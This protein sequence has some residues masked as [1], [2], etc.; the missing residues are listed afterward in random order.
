[1]KHEFDRILIAPAELGSASSEVGLARQ[2]IALLQQQQATW[3]LLRRGYDGLSNVESRIFTFDGFHVNVQFNPGRITSTTA[4]V[5]EKSIRERRC[6][7]CARHL[8]DEQRAILYHDQYLLLCNPYPIFPEHFTIPHIDHRPQEILQAFSAMLDLTRDLSPRY[9]VLYNGPRC[10]ASAPDHLHFQAGTGGVMPF[11]NELG[12][13]TGDR[14]E[15]L[16][17]SKNLRVTC[18]LDYFRSV[19]VAECFSQKQLE[20]V[21]QRMYE[22][23]QRISGGN[24]EPMMNLVSMLRDGRWTLAMFARSKHRPSMFYADEDEKLLV[25]PAAVDLGGVLTLPREKDFRRFSRDLV[26]R[27]F[28]E[29]SLE[30][31]KFAALQTDIKQTL[32]TV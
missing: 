1:M 18:F 11:E 31:E 22:A 10:G 7:L 17:E 25:S 32:R 6:F 14:R 19:I 16:V 26:A 4:K 5:D 15:A 12:M 8:P 20:D 3:G 23:Y 13:I 9:T 27:V 30:E 29:V 24:E 28:E 2:C 21:F